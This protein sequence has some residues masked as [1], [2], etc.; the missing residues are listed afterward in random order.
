MA[1]VVTD[2]SSSEGERNDILAG[3]RSE[4]AAR[5][6][7]AIE[8]KGWTATEAARR[9]SHLLG[10][11]DKFSRAHLW[12]YLNGKSLPRTRYLRALSR[13]LD[14]RPEDLIPPTSRAIRAA[15]ARDL[16]ELAVA[17]PLRAEPAGIVHVRDYGDGTALVQVSER[18]PWETALAVMKLLKSPDDGSE[19]TD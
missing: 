14:V 3:V 10:E 1:G 17:D 7:A 9:V 2:S 18:V 4:F 15:R 19:S 6:R 12:Q 5:L 8:R 11:K 13:A 16:R